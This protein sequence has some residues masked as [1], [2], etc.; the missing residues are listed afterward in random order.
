MPACSA[1]RHGRQEP[2][3][4]L[5]GRRQG[6]KG[7]IFG[8]YATWYQSAAAPTGLYLDGWIQYGDFRNRVQG[9]ALPLERYDS[10][11]WAASIGVGHAFE[12]G[13]AANH[14]YFVE[15]QAQVIHND[16]ADDGHKEAN[17]TVVQSKDAGSWVTRLGARAYARPQE[18]Y[19][20]RVQPF[21]EANW[22][23]SEGHE[24]V[25]FNQHVERLERS[26]DI[27]ELKVGAQ[28]ELGSGW[29][30]WMH[31]GY[32]AGNGDFNEFAGLVGMKYRW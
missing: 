7:S 1:G 17:G 23:H 3:H 8:L 6:H 26:T 25:A 16:Y 4:R 28:A 29:T 5:S 15:P 14:T 31:F 11:A 21:I 18:T 24:A 19:F 27:Y 13:S 2:S 9:E 32:R 20:N 22:W 10:T 12:A 30:G